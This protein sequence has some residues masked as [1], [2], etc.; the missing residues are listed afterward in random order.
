MSQRVEVQSVVKK[1]GKVLLLKQAS[2]LEGSPGKFE[3]PG[4]EIQDNEQPE[5]AVDRS[6]KRS[7]GVDV[8][9]SYLSDVFTYIDQDKRG[10]QRTVIVYVV[11]I[12]GGRSDIQLAP[13]YS[14]YAWKKLSDVQQDAMTDLSYLVLTMHEQKP[15]VTIVSDGAK[16]QNDVSYS[17]RKEGDIVIYS[18]GG[19]RGNPGP[20]AAGYVIKDTQGR[21]THE[22]G[23]YL[24]VTT[25]NQAEYHG[26]R[27]GLE[28]AKELG[29]KSVDFYIDSMLVVNQ[30]NGQ[31]VIRNRELWP[32]HER[33]KELIGQF[34]K[35]TFRHV[36]RELNQQADGTVNKIL[37]A[38]ANKESVNI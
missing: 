29:A 26:V 8:N 35:V 27:L 10:T 14:K 4:A 13:S 20:S 2:A 9:T 37:D 30:L 34:D 25:N 21:L 6:I 36:K 23:A 18:D 24:G 12:S 31:Y 17:G 11:S 33:I 32:I 38:R 7:L 19:S 5:Q 15:G 22:G 28:K 3:L 1:D 16:I